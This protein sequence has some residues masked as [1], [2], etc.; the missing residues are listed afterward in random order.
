[1]HRFLKIALGFY[2]LAT[3]LGVMLRLHQ[4]EPFRWLVF[5]FGVHAHSH[6]LYFGWVGLAIFAL[7]FQ[8]AGATG[9]TEKSVLTGI[10]VASAANFASFL[11]G[12]Y[13]RLSIIISS[14][15]LFIWLGAAVSGWRRLRAVPGVESG[16]LKAGLLYIGLAGIGAMARVVLVVT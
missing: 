16:F 4:L 1:M 6:T 11:H 3:L 8:H 13:S 5:P 10:G 14:I 7:L 2:L 12:G 15:S 9:R